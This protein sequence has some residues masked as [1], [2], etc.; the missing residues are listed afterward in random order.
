MSAHVLP[1]LAVN[2]KSERKVNSLPP[3]GF[4]LVIFG[5]LAHLSNHSAKSHP[6]MRLWRQS[7]NIYDVKTILNMKV[8]NTLEFRTMTI[9]PRMYQMSSFKNNLN[10]KQIKSISILAFCNCLKTKDVISE[11]VK[12]KGNAY[13]HRR[14]Y[15]P[16]CDTSSVHKLTSFEEPNSHREPLKNLYEVW[17]LTSIKQLN[18]V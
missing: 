1:P 2:S 12:K 15:L 18:F 11:L 17:L 5:M 7:I 9:D 3:L 8:L 16:Y 13:N 4:G 10:T 14:P 6:R